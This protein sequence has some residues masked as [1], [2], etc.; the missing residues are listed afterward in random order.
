MTAMRLTLS[1][2]MLMG[3]RGRAC[4]FLQKSKEEQQVKGDCWNDIRRYFFMDR[5]QG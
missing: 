3:E 5:R 2:E 1:V 4:C